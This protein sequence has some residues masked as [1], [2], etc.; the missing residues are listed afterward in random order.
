ML[1]KPD[2]LTSIRQLTLSDLDQRLA[3]IGAERAALS[4]LRRSLVA[5]DRA[6]RRASRQVTPEGVRHAT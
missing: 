1:D 4:S 3:E 5:R 6:K 2:I